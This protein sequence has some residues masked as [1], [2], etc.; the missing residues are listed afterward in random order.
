M[1]TVT[2]TTPI[3]CLT[4]DTRGIGQYVLEARLDGG[5][6]II[7]ECIGCGANARGAGQWVAPEEVEDRGVDPAALR[8]RAVW[9]DGA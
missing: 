5:T 2:L 8:M 3:H 9:A 4:C 7:L 6:G 1:T